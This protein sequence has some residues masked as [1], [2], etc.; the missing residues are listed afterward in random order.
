MSRARRWAWGAGGTAGLAALVIG[1]APWL[2]PQFGLAPEANAHCEREIERIGAVTPTQCAGLG[3]A[4]LLECALAET[5][6][7]VSLQ[8]ALRPGLDALSKRWPRDCAVARI[9]PRWDDEALVE[10]LVASG[11]PEHAADVVRT[12]HA[13]APLPPTPRVRASAGART[14]VVARR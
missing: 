14:I 1:T 5:D 8:A 13:A 6:Y 3:D 9:Q 12:I 2:S 11:G 7:D 10:V 4:A